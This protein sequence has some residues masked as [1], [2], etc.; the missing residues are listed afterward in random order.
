M[1]S[2]HLA[3]A[4]TQSLRLQVTRDGGRSLKTRKL[5]AL[6]QVDS[7]F[8][9][10]GIE[11]GAQ[12]VLNVSPPRAPQSAD[13]SLAGKGATII[14]MHQL[15]ASKVQRQL[16]TSREKLTSMGYTIRVHLPV[17]EHKCRTRLYEKF[18]DGIGAAKR[19]H[20]Q[21]AYTEVRI[22]NQDNTETYHSLTPEEVAAAGAVPA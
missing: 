2:A 12:G 15:H 5:E 10:C 6:D 19:Y 4:P 17:H 8:R 21:R 22:V 16:R 7:I 20:F 9:E 18:K 13:A 1:Q 3:P 11:G 14:T